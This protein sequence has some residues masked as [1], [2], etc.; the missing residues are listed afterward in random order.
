LL[1]QCTGRR[2]SSFHAMDLG[3]KKHLKSV[4]APKHWMVDKLVSVFAPCTSTNLHKLRKCLLLIIF[5]RN[6][7]KYALTGDEVKI[8]MQQFIKIDGKV[9]NDITYSAEFMNIISNFHLI[10]DT[11]GGL[12][13]HRITLKKAK[14][15]LCKVR[16]ISV[17]TKGIPHLVTHN[18]STI[19]YPD[20]LIKWQTTNFFK[21]DTGTLCLVT[22][23]AN[24]GRTGMITNRERY[25]GSFDVVPV[26]D[27]N[28]N[29]FA[30]WLSN[31]FVTGKGNKIQ[32]S[33][34][35]GKDIHLI[36][37][38]ERGKRLVAQW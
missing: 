29:N 12:A 32:I 31:I 23:G 38:E 34:P 6:R 15:K 10:Y 2:W 5:L 33:L 22:R 16:K 7:F 1:Y 9:R 25:T 28:G 14:Y 36:I 35:Q 11:K 24:L 4:A 26:K 13:V 37:A 8:C 19:C 30:T 21:F 18:A 20:S 17:G 27:A 3:P